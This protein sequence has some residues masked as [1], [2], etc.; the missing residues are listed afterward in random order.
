MLL[1]AELLRVFYTLLTALSFVP[2]FPL[3][4]LVLQKV[5]L[6]GVSKRAWEAK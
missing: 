5:A 4:D 1:G 6:C 3:L 2:L